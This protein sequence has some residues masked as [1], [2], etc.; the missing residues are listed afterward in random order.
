ML[1]EKRRAE[2]DVRVAVSALQAKVEAYMATSMR[3]DENAMRQAMSDNLD[4]QRTE[5]NRWRSESLATPRRTL[6][7]LFFPREGHNKLQE[8]DQEREVGSH[9]GIRMFPC[10]QS[11]DGTKR[12]FER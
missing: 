11:R 12:E 1:F 9:V 3:E 4:R 8:L 7:A 5:A 10:S 2:A 6:T